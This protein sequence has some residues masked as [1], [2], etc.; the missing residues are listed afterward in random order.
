MKESTLGRNEF[1]KQKTKLSCL[2]AI[3]FQKGMDL[4]TGELVVLKLPIL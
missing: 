4:I 2:S 1:L 3:M